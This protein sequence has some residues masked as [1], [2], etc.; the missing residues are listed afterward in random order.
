MDAVAVAVGVAFAAAAAGKTEEPAAFDPP[1]APP[2]PPQALNRTQKITVMESIKFF[3]AI[4][5]I[6]CI[7][8]EKKFLE[9]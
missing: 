4:F 1:L 9:R 7:K 3:M 5:C 6:G 8:A 2:L